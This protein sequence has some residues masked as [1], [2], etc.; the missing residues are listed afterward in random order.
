[1][2][3]ENNQKFQTVVISFTST[4]MISVP[5]VNIQALKQWRPSGRVNAYL[6][7]LSPQEYEGKV[8]TSMP[9]L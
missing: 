6:A 8:L 3:A 9:L 5:F 7:F 4:E 1:M 2:V